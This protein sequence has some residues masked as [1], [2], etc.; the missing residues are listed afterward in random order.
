ML[1]KI[2][3]MVVLTTA[4]GISASLSAAESCAELSDRITFEANGTVKDS[5]TNLTWSRCNLGQAW[6]GSACTG[7]KA[8]YTFDEAKAEI[9]SSKVV[10][11]GYRL[12]TLAELL[13]IVAWDCGEPAVH[14]S[15][16]SIESGF[17]WTSTEAFGGFQNTVLMRTGE[18]YPMNQ[19]VASWVLLVK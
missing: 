6:Q 5:K 15:W 2:S 4:L 1:K 17:Y 18:E 13:S 7:N 16:L 19:E 14:R 12:P 9:A 10:E 8:Q 11:Q 3:S